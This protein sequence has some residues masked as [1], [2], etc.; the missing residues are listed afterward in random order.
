M[1]LAAVSVTA[2]D[3]GEVENPD[4][5]GGGGGGGGSGSGD[6]GGPTFTSMITPIVATGNRCTG[7]HGGGTEPNL[8]DYTKLA[9]KYKMKPG[10][11]NILVTKPLDATGKHYGIDYFTAA[12]KTT[13]GNW[14]DSIMPQ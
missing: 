10:A 2:C 1:L 14:I 6:N 8:S 13:V 5:G 4:A 9:A 3:L 12:E 11:S 7:C